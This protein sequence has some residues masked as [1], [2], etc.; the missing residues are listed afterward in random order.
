MFKLSKSDTRQRIIEAALGVFSDKGYE[1]ASTREIAVGAGVSEIT[2]FRHFGNKEN[3]FR[4]A[5]ESRAPVSLLTE[6]LA[7]RMTGDLREDLT[8]LAQTYLQVQ[9][10]HLDLIRISMME[11][12]RNP[13][14]ASIVYMIPKQLQD[15]LAGYLTEL[16][17]R[18]I[19][20]DAD[21]TLLARMFYGQL[22]QHISM[23]C[24]FKDASESLKA[25]SDALVRTLVTLFVNTLVPDAD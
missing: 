3:L 14:Y 11:I 21:F 15:H 18:G 2:L 22:F 25:Q 16:A 4:E 1:A 12:P 6:S 24:S 23:I 8:H 9:F 7:Q 5:L 20:Q 19:I 17:N 10:K 13:S